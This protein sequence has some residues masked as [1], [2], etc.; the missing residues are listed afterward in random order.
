MSIFILEDFG[1]ATRKV[2]CYMLSSV[3]PL[4]QG[5]KS[6]IFYSIL[7]CTSF[8]DTS[9]LILRCIITRPHTIIA[10]TDCLWACRSFPKPIRS[11]PIEHVWDLMRSYIRP[12]QYITNVTRQFQIVWQEILQKYIR[13]LIHTRCQYIYV[14]AKIDNCLHKRP[15]SPY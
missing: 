9:D 2:Y 3:A 4:Q 1:E 6:T 5:S 14:K 8:H 11:L 15:G 12:F 10:S 13:Q 7:C